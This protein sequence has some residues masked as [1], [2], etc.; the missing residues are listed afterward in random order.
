MIKIGTHNLTPISII[1]NHETRL[2]TSN[3]F[4]Q[5][6]NKIRVG[7]STYSFRGLKFWKELPVNLKTLGFSAFKYKLKQ[8]L[9]KLLESTILD[10]W[11]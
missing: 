7:Q 5:K 3:N 10:N 9:L 2:S 6:F 8:Y 4:F 11:N 1:H